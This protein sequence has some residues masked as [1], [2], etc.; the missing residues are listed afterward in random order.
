MSL[1]SNS[2]MIRR[3][4][5][6]IGFSSTGREEEVVLDPCSKTK[7]SNMATRGSSSAPY[8]YFY[9]IDIHKF[10]VLIPFAYSEE[11]FL[12]IINVTLPK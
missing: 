11:D 4:H 5:Q 12:A 8:F 9:I 6:N 3:F 10:R 2:D 7:K 1:Y